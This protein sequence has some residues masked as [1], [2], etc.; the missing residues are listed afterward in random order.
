MKRISSRL[1]QQTDTLFYHAEAAFLSDKLRSSHGPHLQPTESINELE[2]LLSTRP[3]LGFTARLSQLKLAIQDSSQQNAYIQKY[4]CIGVRRFF[5][6]PGAKLYQLRIESFPTLIN[7]VMLII[8]GPTRM[9][10]DV[11]S[12]SEASVRD[13]DLAFA[14]LREIFD[15]DIRFDMLSHLVVSH[16]HIDHF[17]GLQH[18]SKRCNAKICVHKLDARVI[19]HF[20][21]RVSEVI[22]A[23]DGYL[24]QSGIED[25]RRIELLSMYEASKQWFD[26]Q[27]VDVSLCDGDAIA[28]D[29]GVI[30]VPGHCPGLI[31]LQVGDILLTSDHILDRITPHQFPQSITEYAGLDH[32]FASLDKVQKLEG[33]RLA[34]GGHEA[35]ILDLSKRI[36]EIRAFHNK[37]LAQ[38]LEICSE[39]KTIDEISQALFGQSEHYGRLLAIEEAGAHVEYLL[40]KGK[41]RVTDNIP[42]SN[43]PKTPTRY[44]A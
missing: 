13:L 12:G 5:P 39:S 34:L 27:R 7:N 18:L 32:Y 29:F 33:V 23:L 35:P 19:T 8:D 16:A 43:N 1:L 20:K 10:F 22:K 6:K 40:T 28:S 24:I 25:A 31:C 3:E 41:L 11:G 37:R 21:Q 38:V 14:V 36:D 15:E 44:I 17:G 2:A 4:G 30:H 26:S 9:L 42:T